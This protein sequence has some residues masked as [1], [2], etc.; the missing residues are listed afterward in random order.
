MPERVLVFL[1]ESV[2]SVSPAM[3]EAELRD[4]D[5]MTLA[6]TLELPEGEEAAVEA[7]WRC[8]RIETDHASDI[9]GALLHFHPA[10]R[11]VRVRRGPP[12]DGEIDEL[13]DE[14]AN[15]TDPGAERVRAALR[16]TTEVVAFEMGIPGSHHLGATLAEVLAFFLA[17]RG[18]GLVLFYHR[19]F[20]AP[21]DRGSALFVL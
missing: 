20:A 10:H 12:L 11:P 18:F 13:L 2:G 8:F 1:R 21:D 5:L 16:A 4:A 17:E 6:E 3:L 19:E 7:M 9:D 15:R 14:I